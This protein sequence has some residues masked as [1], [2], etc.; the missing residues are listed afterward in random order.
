MILFYSIS[1][2]HKIWNYARLDTQIPTSTIT[3]SIV[4]PNGSTLPNYM[5]YKSIE[6]VLDPYY[7]EKFVLLARYQYKYNGNSYSG[8]T[9]LKEKYLNHLTA[10]EAI[11][12]FSSQN[13]KIWLNHSF[14]E[15]SSFEKYFPLKEIIYTLI[16]CALGIYFIGLFIYINKSFT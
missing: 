7:Y 14:P 13:P 11:D 1:T 5:K 12:R 6:W 9:Q 15:I 16:I 3:W 2:G 10:Q 4:H 8:E